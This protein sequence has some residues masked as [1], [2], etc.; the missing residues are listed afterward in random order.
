MGGWGLFRRRCLGRCNFGLIGFA[1]FA[2]F[3]YFDDFGQ[4]RKFGDFLA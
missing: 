2:W 3:L 4:V 1:L